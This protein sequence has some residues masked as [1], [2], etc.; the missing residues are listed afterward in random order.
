MLEHLQQ[1]LCEILLLPFYKLATWAILGSVTALA[2][3][4]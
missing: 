1:G 3:A 4:S 2:C